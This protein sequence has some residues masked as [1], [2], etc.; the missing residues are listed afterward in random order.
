VL[1]YGRSRGF[2]TGILPLLEIDN[3]QGIGAVWRGGVSAKAISAAQFFSDYQDYLEQLADVANESGASRFYVGSELAALTRDPNATP[4]WRS[5]ISGVR[6]ALGEAST[7]RLS[8]AANHDEFEHV[9]F[10]GN[11]DEIGV[12]AY[13]SLASARE[14][15]GPARPGVDVLV[16][17][18][19]RELASLK[20]FSN[21]Q[22]RQL[23][24]SEWGT[25]PLD[26]TTSQ[27]WHWNP[28]DAPDVAEQ[29]NAYEALLSSISTE[30]DWLSGC[31]LWHWRMP[32]NEDSLYGI[33]AS[34][35]ASHYI[36]QYSRKAHNI[37]HD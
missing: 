15:R 7:C 17:R 27:P 18:W 6:S 3:P 25:V 20:Q 14:A 30:G 19:R 34:H 2:D 29:V 31:D 22:D 32:G 21:R 11:L 28:S 12:D 10:W 9:P 24:I 1:Q 8:Y 35:G 33:D 13:F 5:L 23:V 26:L 37:R 4:S 16:R 36:R